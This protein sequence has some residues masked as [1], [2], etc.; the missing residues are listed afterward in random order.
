[1]QE[2]KR[3]HM[4]GQLSARDSGERVVV[5][6]WVQRRRDLGGLIFLDIRDRTGIIQVVA[7]G[8]VSKEAFETAGTLRSEFVVGIKGTVVMRK[9][10]AVNP[11]LKTGEVEVIAE[12]IEIFSRAQT[13]PIYMRITPTLPKPFV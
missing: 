8:E 2:L 10:D 13:P 7:D 3:T 1:M 6:G 9:A 12:A 11:K 5:T 4:C